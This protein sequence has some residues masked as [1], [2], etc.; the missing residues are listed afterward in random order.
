MRYCSP[1]YEE[2]EDFWVLME[3]N[4][5][6]YAVVCPIVWAQK[7]DNEMANKWFK[8]INLLAYIE[9]YGSVDNAKQYIESLMSKIQQD[10]I[11]LKDK[12]LLSLI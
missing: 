4:G 9:Q 12:R 2:F 11:I 1:W 10:M 6:A 8:T 3:S 5:E 7:S